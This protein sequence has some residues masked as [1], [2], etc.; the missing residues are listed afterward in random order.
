MS[1]LVKQ[2]SGDRAKSYD[3]SRVRTK[4]YQAE[5][6]AFDQLFSLAN[7]RSVFD[8]P[9]GTGR[10]L[11]F[12]AERN[13]RVLGIDASPD[14]LDEANRKLEALNSES[15]RLERGDAFDRAFFEGL[16]ERFDLVVCV[17]F[18]N[19]FPAERIEE[20]VRNLDL[21]ANGKV[22]IGIG[23]LRGRPGSFERLRAKLE[24]WSANLRRKAKGKSLEHGHDTGRF[25]ILTDSIGWREVQRIPI[26]S[27]NGR[28][29][30]FVLFEK[31][32]QVQ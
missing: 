3:D 18:L 27:R 11:E 6:A 28:D 20:V 1:D 21:V 30:A 23:F 12:Y 7:P 4:R 9:V 24:L 32:P 10:W 2:Y 19:W 17:R 26:F 22:L 14:M 29:N 15:I 16:G 13:V 5:E 8:L 25:R 31:T